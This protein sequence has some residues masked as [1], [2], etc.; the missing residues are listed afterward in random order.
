MSGPGKR[1]VGTRVSMRH[2][3]FTLVSHLSE[4]YWW[5]WFWCSA[6]RVTTDWEPI[7]SLCPCLPHGKLACLYVGAGS[8][9]MLKRPHCRA[10]S[11]LS[12]CTL[13]T[14]LPSY[15]NNRTVVKKSVLRFVYSKEGINAENRWGEKRKK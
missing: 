7:T 5:H 8:T 2:E 15:T 1:S 13:L 9:Q 6:P 4:G 3:S 10:T 12:C 14:A 11:V